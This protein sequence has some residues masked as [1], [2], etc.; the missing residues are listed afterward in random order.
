MGG[1]ISMKSG[2]ITFYYIP[3]QN[4]LMTRG[5]RILRDKVELIAKEQGKEYS[6]YNTLRSS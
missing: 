4:Q 1:I 3:L 5:L 6:L 2:H